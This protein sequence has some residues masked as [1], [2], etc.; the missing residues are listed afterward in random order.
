MACRTLKPLLA[1]IAVALVVVVPLTSGAQPTGRVLKIGILE[2]F[3]AAVR[4]NLIEA[5]RQGLRQLGY[6][7]RRNY[8]LEARFADGKLDRLPELAAE[9][10][11]LNVD[12]IVASSTQAIRAAQQATKTI[13]IIMTTVGDPVGPGFVASIA[14]PGGNIT[15]L[16]IQAPE[17]IAKRLQLL[18]EAVPN[19]SRVGVVWDPRI[20]HEVHGFKEAE[21]AATSLGLT[22]VSLEVKRAEELESSFATMARAGANGLLVFENAITVNNSKRI[23][24]LAI[25]HR[26]P[27]VYGLPDFA[28]AGG[29]LVYGP[30]RADNYRKAAIFV[31]KIVKGAKPGDLPVEQPTKFELIVNVKAAKAHGIAIPPSLLLRADLVLE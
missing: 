25:K 31:D 20:S 7:E 30:V 19:V 21:T 6:E 27:G 1:A 24:D 22:L 2:P 10:V 18:K 29:L 14:K 26:L 9:L 28:E 4:A 8:V 3:H 17:L 13:P 11:K 5:F 12:V 16:S 15:G 23:V